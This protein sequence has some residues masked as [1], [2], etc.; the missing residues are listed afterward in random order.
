MNPV[1]F[2]EQRRAY[3]ARIAALG[4]R[5][6]QILRLATKIHNE[7][8]FAC[9]GAA[10]QS[11]RMEERHEIAAQAALQELTNLLLEQPAP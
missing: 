6:K 8:G 1:V 5:D 10:Q 9:Q 7:M 3:I 11:E 4:E 2:M